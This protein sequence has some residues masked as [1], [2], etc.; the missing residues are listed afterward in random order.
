MKRHIALVIKVRVNPFSFL[1]NQVKHG[2]Y[3]TRTGKHFAVFGDAFFGNHLF[4]HFVWFIFHDNYLLLTLS[5]YTL[6]TA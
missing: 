3:F 5:N 2:V 6:K 4:F 1:L